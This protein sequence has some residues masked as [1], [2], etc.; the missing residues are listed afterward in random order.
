M[1]VVGFIGLGMMGSRIAA[2]LLAK[3]YLVAGYNRTPEKAA[4]LVNAGLQLCASPREVAEVAD[5]TMSMVSNDDALIAIADGADG[6]LAGLSA[7][8]I[9]VEMSTVSPRLSRD[10]AQQVSARG[11]HMLEAPVS[12]SIPAVESGTLVIFVGGNA[13]VLEHVRP[14]LEE[15]SQ[16]IIHVGASGQAV[17]TK[18][19][20]NL[21]L[22]IQLAALFEGVLLAEKS[23]VSRQQA[24]DSL[25]NSAAASPAMKYR[26]PLALN[27]PKEVWFSVDMM[28]K[29]VRLALDLGQELGVP[30]PTVQLSYDLLLQA[31]SM[32]YGEEDFAALFKVLADMSGA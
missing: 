2:R 11:A 15:L 28:V 32:G 1:A 3:G 27:P 6:V 20:I 9:Y 22:P 18:I 14:I 21:G 13:D 17:T 16:K 25:L 4:V 8:K 5:I 7:G 26:A 23:G 29:D 19:A 30:L 12:G 31:Q 10:L 24:L